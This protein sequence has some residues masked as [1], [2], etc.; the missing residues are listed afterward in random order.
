MPTSKLKTVSELVGFPPQFI[1]KY[2][3]SESKDAAAN[4]PFIPSSAFT[5]FHQEITASADAAPEGGRAVH[6]CRRG[7][8]AY[9]SVSVTP[10]AGSETRE[11]IVAS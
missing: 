7:F 6:A 8:A 5:D 10:R 11:P 9:L 4:L 2:Q 1:C 3:T